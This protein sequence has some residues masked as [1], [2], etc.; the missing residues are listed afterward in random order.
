[1]NG[2][3]IPAIEDG[4]QIRWSSPGDAPPAPARRARHTQR[5]PRTI[6]A[7]RHDAREPRMQRHALKQSADLV[8][9]P[10]STAPRRE[11]KDIAA[12]MRSSLG[13]SNHSNV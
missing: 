13:R 2:G 6:R 10:W 12:A 11:S 4:Q 3:L 5:S 8:S 9:R 7:R 1:M